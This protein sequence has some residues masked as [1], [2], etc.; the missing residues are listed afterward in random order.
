MP[1]IET[2][3]SDSGGTSSAEAGSAR[4]R[5]MSGW[6]PGQ[7]GTQLLDDLLNLAADGL[8]ATY[9]SASST[10]VYTA[11]SNGSLENPG[12]RIEG[13]STRYSAIAALG[14]GCLD[15]TEQ[16]RILGGD[17][18]LDVAAQA[19]AT[20][21]H[22]ADV[23]AT[24]LACWAAAESGAL[25]GEIPERL[26]SLVTSNDALPT[27]DTSWAVTAL[28]ARQ[29][30]VGDRF[31]RSDTVELLVEQLLA[32]Q[33]GTGLFPHVIP[34]R[35]AHPLRRH[36]G[37]F[38]DQ[39]YPIQ[40]LA[41]YHAAVGSPRALEAANRCAERICALQGS[42]GQWWWHYD[43]RTGRVVEEYPV[44]SVHQHAMGPMALIE[45]AGAG[46]RNFAPK[47]ASGLAWLTE[48]PEV[49]DPL[50]DNDLDVVWRSVRR[51]EPRRATRTTRAV[52][53][54]AWPGAKIPLLDRVAPPT[55][56]DAEC[57]P[58]ELGWLLYAWLRTEA[59]V[60]EARQRKTGDGPAAHSGADS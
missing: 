10:F 12:L 57:R 15:E 20:A 48:R 34:E 16:R 39:V 27:V 40:A 17:T 55:R 45:L 18:V 41:R 28:L 52:L 26:V 2:S 31:A 38:A 7:N 24:A 32:A 46:G 36:V 22:S 23:G 13:T 33:H 47:V 51:R 59:G 1:R 29:A 43:T 44:Y 56:I 37:C 30:A 3:M 8:A 50:I 11:R 6:V 5:E 60:A 9:D 58:Y 54:A 4:T 42:S 14:L 49:S 19:V 53:T 21:A 35:S 25:D